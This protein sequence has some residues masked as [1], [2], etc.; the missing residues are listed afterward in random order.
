MQG[1]HVSGQPGIEYTSTTLLLVCCYKL[2]CSEE[3]VAIQEYTTYQH[4]QG[5]DIIVSPCGLF[6]C[7]SHPFLGPTPDGTVYDPSNTKQPFGFIEVKYLFSYRD[8]T[9]IE[10]TKSS[11]FCCELLSNPDGSQTLKLR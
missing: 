9:P 1:R 10:A 5:R 3:P 6:V 7:E 2:G 11:G 8:C 4:D